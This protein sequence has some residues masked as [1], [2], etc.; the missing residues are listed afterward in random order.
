ML[1]PLYQ[2][3]LRAHLSERQYLTLQLL[4]LLLQSHRQVCLSRLASVFPQPIQYTSRMRSIQRFLLLPQLSVKLL[5]FPILKAWLKQEYRGTH[6]N[7]TQRRARGRLWHKYGDYLIV[8]LDR[9]Q[10]RKQNVLM[11][12]VRWGTH[13]LPVYW[14]LLP[15]LGNTCLGQQKQVLVSVLQLLQPYPV[16]VVADREFHSAKLATW[17]QSKGVEVVL[18][19]KKSAYVQSEEVESQPL[20]GLGFQPGKSYFFGQVCFN[21]KNPIGPF[22]LVVHWKRQYRGKKCKEPWSLLTTLSNSQQ[23]LAIY[24]ARWGIETMFRDCK[25]GGYNLEATYVNR[26]RLLSLILLIAMAYMLATCYGEALKQM[27]VQSYLTRRQNQP[28]CASHHSTFWIG[29]CGYAWCY[30]MEIWAAL[31][32]ELIRLKPHK[33]LY[34]QRGLTALSLIQSAS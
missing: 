10:W 30:A 4:L 17:L 13:A 20:K 3:V 11:A 23:V 22:H 31:M 9:T 19:Q 25:S 6:L 26:P 29:L 33:R 18:R 28:Q 14:E 27:G 2:N 12:S 34:F 16:V 24:R 21:K 15:Q 5:W 8:I 1:P 7:R 32:G